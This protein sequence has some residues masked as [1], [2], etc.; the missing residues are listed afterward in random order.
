MGPRG[1]CENDP[2][3]VNLSFASRLYKNRFT[4]IFFLNGRLIERLSLERVVSECY[5]VSSTYDEGIK[6]NEWPF[7]KPLRG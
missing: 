3:T 6:L 4:S 7:E 2:D 5:G 1:D